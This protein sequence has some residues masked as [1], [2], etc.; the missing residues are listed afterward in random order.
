MRLSKLITIIAALTISTAARAYD[1]PFPYNRIANA[2][3]ENPTLA[4]VDSND[5]EL[6]TSGERFFGSLLED[7]ASAKTCINMECYKFLDDETGR[8]VRDAIVAKAR[9]GVTVRVVIENVTHFT[10]PLKFYED[11]RAQGVRILYATDMYRPLEPIIREINNREHRKTTIIDD[12][13]VST[14]GFN[15]TEKYLADWTDIHLRITGPAAASYARL[16]YN[17]WHYLGGEVPPSEIEVPAAA[18]DVTVQPLTGG[19][20]LSYIPDGIIKALD[21]AQDYIWFQTGYFSPPDNILE[22][23]GRA[24]ARGVDV[25]L[26]ISERVDI[27]FADFLN[28]YYLKKA[29]EKGV[30]VYLYQ[31]CFNHSKTIVC[32]DEFCAVGS[33]NIVIRSMYVNYENYTFIYGRDYTLKMK[34]MHLEREK[35]C[36]QLTLEEADGWSRWRR[37]LQRVAN[38]IHPLV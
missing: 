35:L 16:F 27:R 21:N 10:Q 4:P 5:V 34:Q 26:M 7:I 25:R 13:I 17:Y 38:I 9:E 19:P 14:G 11:M 6:I 18:G 33:A 20:G 15:L 37:F 31:P 3:A 23:L 32:D 1:I 12:R 36:R 24:A 22:A 28:E 29:L 2:S 8:M 30:K